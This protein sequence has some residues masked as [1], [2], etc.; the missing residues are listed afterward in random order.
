MAAF[1]YRFPLDR[2]VQRF[3][4]GGDLAV[5]RWLGL[6]LADRVRA[7]PLPDL[8][9]PP[10]LSESRLRARGFNQALELAKVVGSELGVAVAYRGVTRSRDTSPQPGLS[11]GARQ[12]NLRDAF[13]C[14]LDLGGRPVAIVDDVLTTGATAGAFARVLRAAG[15]RSVV[16]WVV[17]RT[18]D[19]EPTPR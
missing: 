19:P 8:L 4:F 5:G 3:K 15:A 2:L 16:V 6:R 7:E 11:R 10:P 9:L 14:R 18:P 17:A 12:E 1:S 13:R